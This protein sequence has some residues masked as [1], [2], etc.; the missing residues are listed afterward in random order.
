MAVYVR[1]SGKDNAG[2]TIRLCVYGA[3][4]VYIALAAFSCRDALPLLSQGDYEP[5]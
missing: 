5:A 4:A 3:A 1:T 2:R